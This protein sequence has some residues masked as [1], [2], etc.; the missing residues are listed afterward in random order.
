MNIEQSS[1]KLTK[2]Y[3]KLS[4]FDEYGNSVFL[5]IL[6]TVIVILVHAYFSVMIKIQPIKND[7]VNQRCKLNVLPFA[8]LINK[9]PDKTASEFTQE[10]F[11]YCVQNMLVPVTSNSVDPINYLVS[12]FQVINNGLVDAIN[13]IRIMFDSIRNDFESVSED[14]MGRL[15]NFMIPIQ[16]IIVKIRDMFAKVAGV[17]V[18]AIYTSIG[19]YYTLKSL[20]GSIVTISISLLIALVALIILSFAF[21]PWLLPITLS[22]M[23]FY[24]AAAIPLAIIVVFLTETMGIPVNMGIPQQPSM[25]A[26]SSCFDKNTPIYLYCADEK[27]KTTPI[28]EI[29]LGDVLRDGGVVTAIMKLS[30][31]NIEMYNL[32]G[33]I[34]SGDHYVKY[35]KNWIP[36]KL[37]PN[38]RLLKKY[39][40]PFIYCLNTTSKQIPI[41]SQVRLFFMDW[42]EIFPE[43]LDTLE[44]IFAEKEEEDFYLSYIHEY[45]DS[46]LSSETMIPMKDKSLVN[47]CDVKIGDIL[48]KGEKVYGLVE[49]DSSDIKEHFEYYI[50]KEILV[51]SNIKLVK[52][53]EDFEKR[54]VD[55]ESGN[56]KF[57]L[58]HLLTDKKSFHLA[59]GIKIYDYN[60]DNFTI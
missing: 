30:T 56:R 50:G 43:K 41:Y 38:A 51:G 59:G 22:L 1:E 2:L 24:V 10:N 13:D 21:L 33:V 23:S 12:S 25:P 54:A 7:W 9:P 6:L 55:C 17:A 8:G 53:L 15:I 60:S 47:I 28:S 46:G 32:L 49:I 11:N 42:D 26:I 57:R 16:Q 36:V 31:E 44:K 40:E 35:L 45:F 3:G 52:N 4:Y 5:F 18:S 48:E 27:V 39:K 29:N 19:T 58:F 37:H 34:V 14:V 20:L